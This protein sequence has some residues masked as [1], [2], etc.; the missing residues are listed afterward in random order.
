[1]KKIILF[2]VCGDV[3]ADAQMRNVG[4]SITNQENYNFKTRLKIT[5]Q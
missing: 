2:M 5:N 4:D 3:S 1:M